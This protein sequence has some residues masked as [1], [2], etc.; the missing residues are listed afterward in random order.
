MTSAVLQL[1]FGV[2]KRSFWTARQA[3]N[4]QNV[5]PRRV[6]VP[7]FCHDAKVIK[8]A[9]KNIW[10]TISKRPLRSS[11]GA[12][13]LGYLAL[14]PVLYRFEAAKP[15]QAELPMARWS[16]AKI[17]AQTRQVLHVVAQPSSAQPIEVQP[18]MAQPDEARA[19]AGQSLAQPVN[20]SAASRPA[21]VK[22]QRALPDLK[23]LEP[24]DIYT[25]GSRATGDLRLKFAATIYNA[26]RGPLETRGARTAAGQLEVFQYVYEGEKAKRGRP[27]GTFD[28]D[29][30][31]GHLH[32]DEFARY[33]LWTA[34]AD[35]RLLERVAE[36]QKVGFCLMD[37]K[38]MASNRT[39]LESGL[40]GETGGPVYA[41]CREDIQGISPGWGDEY[42]SQLYEQDLDLTGVPGGRYALVITTN[43]NRKIEESSYDNNA[44]TVYLTLE[45][46][47]VAGSPEKVASSE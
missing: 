25:I 40:I 4:L 7:F 15:R 24:Y 5:R 29:H 23:P 34:G 9:A 43:P 30:R 35:G 21:A 36:N 46:E 20:Q 6:Y 11:L 44:A 18:N 27:V 22:L 26:G 16:I 14:G 42:V 2:L 41:G 10:T 32:F 17:E 33:E 39:H 19:G 38:N 8:K 31:H 28:Y 1:P 3:Q 37:I 45:G 47:K 13:F 12:I